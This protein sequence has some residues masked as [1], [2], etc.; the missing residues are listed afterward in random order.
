VTVPPRKTVQIA[1]HLKAVHGP[2]KIIH[3][4]YESIGFAI[5]MSDQDTQDQLANTTKQTMIKSNPLVET[6]YE[7]HVQ[8]HES[9]ERRRL[10]DGRRLEGSNSSVII[11]QA[12]VQKEGFNASDIPTLDTNIGASLTNAITS[13]MDVSKLLKPGA[14]ELGHPVTTVYTANVGEGVATADEEQHPPPT[15]PVTGSTAAA[16]TAAP[17]PGT[18]AAPTPGTTA[19][20][21]PGT[22]VAPTTTEPL[23]ASTT[24]PNTPPPTPGPSPPAATTQ[25]EEDDSALPVKLLWAAFII[26]LP[27]FTM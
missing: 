3:L 21:T 15:T 11:E 2:T 9:T 25:G 24:A 14:K 19:A 10:T 1:D 13:T 18:T 4:H 20:P 16:T 8:Y 27:H 26:M 17:T 12:M 22:T 5:L 7:L 23:A 6:Y